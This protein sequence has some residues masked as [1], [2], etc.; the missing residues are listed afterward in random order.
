MIYK[1]FM[2]GI[3]F[4]KS[5]DRVFICFFFLLILSYVQPVRGQDHS[6][7]IGAIKSRQKIETLDLSSDESLFFMEALLKRDA[8]ISGFKIRQRL[9]SLPYEELTGLKSRAAVPG[10]GRLEDMLSVC[11]EKTDYFVQNV[12]ILFDIRPA[13][14]RAPFTEDVRGKPHMLSEIEPFAEHLYF[15]NPLLRFKPDDLIEAENGHRVNPGYKEKKENIM[16]RTDTP[17]RP[18]IPSPPGSS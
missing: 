12:D 7:L 2:C 10:L 13:R 4:L 5:I 9:L 3:G 15:Y 6:G 8:I 17:S 16:L 11:I 14:H 18:C 1:R